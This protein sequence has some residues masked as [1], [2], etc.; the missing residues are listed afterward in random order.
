MAQAEADRAAGR[1]S[2]RGMHPRS[3]VQPSP[4]LD[5]PLRIQQRGKFLRVIAG[6]VHAHDAHSR[7][8]GPWSINLH[9]GKHAKAGNK[10]SRESA[11][12]PAAA[13]DTLF[14][15]MAHASFE[16][17]NS[18]QVEIARLITVWQFPRLE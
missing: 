4:D 3:T 17:R 7:L 8:I 14:E 16:S 18:R 2:Q 12:V 11:N 15:Q 6:H 5:R 10:L 13:G 9:R 1:R